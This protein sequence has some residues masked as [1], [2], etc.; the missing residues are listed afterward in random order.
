MA[1][2]WHYD[3]RSLDLVEEDSYSPAFEGDSPELSLAVLDDFLDSTL[4]NVS[5]DAPLL[6]AEWRFLQRI[7]ELHAYVA[8]FNGLLDAELSDDHW[9]RIT[10]SFEKK[11]FSRLAGD[12]LDRFLKAYPDYTRSLEDGQL[13]YSINILLAGPGEEAHK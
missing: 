11:F 5:R 3:Y 12:T 7:Q 8:Q 10:L 9:G 1:Y 2:K 6:A 13:T 4:D